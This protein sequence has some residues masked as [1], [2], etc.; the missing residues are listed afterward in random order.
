[1]TNVIIRSSLSRNTLAN[2]DEVIAAVPIPE[3]SALLHVSGECGLNYGSGLFAMN[4]VFYYGAAG[5]LIPVED[6]DTNVALDTLWDRFVTKDAD[7]AEDAID[8]DTNTADAAPE[9]EPGEGNVF[10]IIDD[11]G[12]V[13][14]IFR[15]RKKLTSIGKPW[16]LDTTVKWYPEDKFKI[17]IK[18]G[19]GTRQPTMALWG[20]SNPELVDI[21]TT[22]PVMPTEVE[23][24][25]LQYVDTMIEDAWKALTG[26]ADEEAVTITLPYDTAMNFFANLLEPD[27]VQDATSFTLNPTT[28]RSTTDLTATIKVPGTFR[29]K[30]LTS[31]N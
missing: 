6:P 24:S 18:N 3:K 9:F 14:Q 15:R 25:M 23:W 7:W 1:M 17:S 30:T 27:L 11:A 13:R 2:V 20:L 12:S 28:V 31:E 4:N 26:L 16:T 10:A 8:L 19:Y 5:F 29:M 22:L 21:T